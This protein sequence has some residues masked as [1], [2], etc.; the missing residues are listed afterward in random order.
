MTG[1]AGADS[2]TAA[3]PGRLRAEFLAFYLVAPV[4]GAVLLPA[5]AMFAM[6][7]TLTALGLGLLQ[8]TPG[9]LWRDLARG[10]GRIDW[11]L[12]G[13]IG[14]L[15]AVTGLALLAATA[16]G[17]AFG[18]LRERPGLMAAILVLYPLVSALPQEIIFRVLYFRRYGALLPS[19]PAG[20]ALNAGVFSLAHLMYWSIL[21]AAMTFVG[22]LA[23]AFAYERR[24]SL[25]TAVAA[26]G[27]AGNLIFLIG[28]GVYFYSGNV[29]RP[30]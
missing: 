13:G 22:G 10:W 1:L 4:A 27:V 24:H 6:L 29:V 21:V 11:R 28:L 14:L 9:F 20:I 19:G 25:P 16:P 17:A 12:V 26:H 2:G 18:L 8:L 23:F 30:F 3:R 15:T 5:N 7:F